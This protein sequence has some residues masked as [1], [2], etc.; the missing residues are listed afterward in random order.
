MSLCQAGGAGFLGELEQ[1]CARSPSPALVAF[2]GAQPGRGTD[3]NHGIEPQNITVQQV[4]PLQRGKEKLHMGQASQQSLV[5]LVLPPVQS[6]PCALGSSG[7]VAE[8]CPFPAGR[9][10]EG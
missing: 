1:C 6:H 8:M 9:T 10:R 4:M 3:P 2:Q 5:V 7:G